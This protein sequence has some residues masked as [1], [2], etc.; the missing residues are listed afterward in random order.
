[1]ENMTAKVSCFARAFHYKNNDFWVFKDEMAEKLLGTHEY[2][3]IAENMAQGIK[4]FAPDFKGS[5]EESLRFIADKQLSPSVLGRSAFCEQHLKK[6]CE[7]GC[8]QYIIFAAGYDTFSFREKNPN[9]KVYNLDLPEV[10]ADRKEKTEKYKLSY[11]TETQ[12]IPCNLSKDSLQQKLAEYGFDE[13]EKTFGSLLGI[14]YYLAK[15]DFQKLLNKISK[16]IPENSAI[17][18]DFPLENT[19]TESE[20]NRKLAKAAN[21]QMKAK[22]SYEEMEKLLVANGFQICEY[23]DAN[24]MTE[25]YFEAYNSHNSEHTMKAP[26]GVGYLFA[27][28]KTV[29]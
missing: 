13:T 27:I 1:M 2:Q 21:E 15:E 16:I 3:A 18:L 8:R 24:K 9:L 5:K 12:E 20:K 22:Y 25:K 7:A 28:K 26:E 14:S 17:C 10:I 29:K 23:L 4:F 11:K 19:G 6:E